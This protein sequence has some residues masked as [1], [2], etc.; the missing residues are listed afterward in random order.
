M[1]AMNSGK[2]VI[3]NL[4][5]FSLVIGGTVAFGHFAYSR[6]II[7][8]AGR[9]GWIAVLFAGL[10]GMAVAYLLSKLAILQRE[11]S[12]VTHAIEV[13]GVW[14]GGATGILYSVYFLFIGAFALHLLG[15]VLGSIYPRTPREV[16]LLF[17]LLAVLWAVLAGLEV[18]A[19]SVQ[20]LL[21][22]LIAMGI[23]AS[24][25]AMPD[26]DFSQ[27]LPILYRGFAP[28]WR[29]TVIMLT[30]GAEMIAFNMITPHVKNRE[31]LVKQSFILVLAI[32]LFYIGPIT[33]PVTLFGEQ[34]ARFLAYPT[35]TELQYINASPL[36][37]RLDLFAII[38]W[39]TGAYFRIIIYGFCAV[40]AVAQLGG[41]KQVNSYTIPV[42][43]TLVGMSLLMPVDRADDF[44][45]LDTAYPVIAIGMGVATPAALLLST[46][47]KQRKSRAAAP[48]ARSKA[49]QTEQASGQGE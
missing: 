33:G 40:E 47:F 36:L 12:F 38:L 5:Y 44:T 27:L 26:R 20:L 2:V 16:W 14:A 29:G 8:N 41:A 17:L 49:K 1:D 21:P 28:V 15:S 7:A 18:I 22:L 25:L 35:F 6:M 19:R 42:L 4:Q 32:T 3:S 10:L 13:W 11:R 24:L 45:F 48:P 30:M 9:D 23:A 43:T 31:A 39:V 37:E 46:L 34:V